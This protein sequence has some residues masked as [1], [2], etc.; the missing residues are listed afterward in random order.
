MFN[1][2]FNLM[3]AA[4]AC[5]LLAVMAQGLYLLPET[6]TRFFPE[7]HQERELDRLVQESWKLRQKTN[8]LEGNLEILHACL[9]AGK[10]SGH[11]GRW[12]SLRELWVILSQDRLPLRDFLDPSYEAKL[13]ETHL[14]L[15]KKEAINIDRRFRFLEARVESYRPEQGGI[16]AAS[17][18]FSTATLPSALQKVYGDLERLKEKKLKL[19]GRLQQLEILFL[20][21]HA[22]H[23]LAQL[24]ATGEAP[25]DRCGLPPLLIPQ[26]E[27]VSR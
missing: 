16:T 26:A 20:D 6:A 3:K 13:L 5:G 19:A 24:E 15:A 1:K 14:Y 21:H 10:M 18:S 12:P 11:G 9:R 7:K 8:I 25:S 22:P 4:L 17:E 2:P 27:A 23:S